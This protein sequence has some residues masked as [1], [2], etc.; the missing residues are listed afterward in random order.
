MD[1]NTARVQLG[2]KS[3]GVGVILTILFGGL[4]MFYLS[5]FWGIVGLLVEG[6][7]ILIT[8]LSFGLFGFSLPV[9]HVVCVI[10]TVVYINGHNRSL[11]ESLD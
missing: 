3:M 5:I 7:L 6:A 10:I 1:K 9:W 4:G 8:F 2:G 11:L